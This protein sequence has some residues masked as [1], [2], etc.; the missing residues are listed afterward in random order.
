MAVPGAP[1]NLS[2]E[3]TNTTTA[4]LLWTTPSDDGGFG[5]SGYFIERDLNDAGFAT[6][7][8][9]TG[10]ANVSFIDS[11]LTA[12][13]NAVYR[14]SA[15]NFDGTGPASNEASMTTAN[16]ESQILQQQL[17]NNWSL[18]GELSNV[19]VGDMTEVVQF[20]DRQQ[21][22]GNFFAKAVTVQKIN[23]LGNENVIEHPKFFEQSDTFEVTCFLQVIDGAQDV[24]SVWV[25]LMDQMTGEV[26]RILK[27]IYSP[28]SD[29]GEFFSTTIGWT[30]DDTFFPDDPMLVR[31]LQ[32]TLTRLVGG[33]DDVF[34]GYKAILAFSSILSDGDSL[35]T[36]NYLYTEVEN[37]QTIQGWRNLPYIT[38]DAISTTAI[39]VYYRGA[40]SGRFSCMMYL[41]KADITP[42]TLNS[43]SQIFLPQ[44]NGELGTVVFLQSNQNTESPIDV[45]TE[46]IS[47]N[48]TNVEKVS[49]T[50]QLVKYYLRGNLTGPTTSAFLGSMEYEAS[51]KMLYEDDSTEMSYG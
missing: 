23:Q 34:L 26:S 7:V 24:F 13:D 50:E 16:S 39:P 42:T 1:T 18:T 33:E 8:A 51:G 36:Q 20:F 28:S 15:I 29:T 41:R 19:I 44:A 2:A 17:F 9:T 14:V 12:R 46:S 48:I 32:F 22:P 37:I 4:A 30:K 10:N 35:P 40:F 3:A 6:L 49:E 27:T 31:T 38:T 21:I 11:T 47:V 45:L 43:L 5:I 25:D